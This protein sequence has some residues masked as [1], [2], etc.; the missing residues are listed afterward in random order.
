MLIHLSSRQVSFII[1]KKSYD[2]CIIGGLAKLL[3]CIPVTRPSDRREPGKGFII[4]QEKE[5]ITGSNTEFTK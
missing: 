2:T 5:T 3:G 1:A 4:K